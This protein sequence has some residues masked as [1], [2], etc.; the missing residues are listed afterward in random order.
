MHCIRTMYVDWHKPIIIPVPRERFDSSVMLF[1][2]VL[3]LWHFLYSVGPHPV[4]SRHIYTFVVS[5]AFMAGAASQVG[6]A[7][8]SRAP[9]SHLWFTGVRE[10]PPCCSFVSD[11]VTVHQF[12]CILHWHRPRLSMR[13]LFPLQWH[14]ETS[15]SRC[16]TSP[17][18]VMVQNN[19]FDHIT[20]IAHYTC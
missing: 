17:V 16:T 6:D 11:T 4:S 9:W 1:P 19:D 3:R 2:G 8:S 10:C 14:R 13:V 12:F 18:R 15:D 20:V 5:R 7:E